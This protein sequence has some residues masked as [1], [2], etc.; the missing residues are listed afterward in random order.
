MAVI[1]DAA[2]AFDDGFIYNYIVM[3]APAL[4][5][6]ESPMRVHTDATSLPHSA[7][8]NSAAIDKLDPLWSFHSCHGYMDR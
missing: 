6:L 3:L 4:F 1:G 8:T 7:I 5:L 2:F